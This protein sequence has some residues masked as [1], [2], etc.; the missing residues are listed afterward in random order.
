MTFHTRF[1]SLADFQ[2]GGVEVIDD[3]PKHYVFSN[4]FDVASRSK[5]WERV[6]VAKNFEYVIEAARATGESPYWSARHDEF[7]LCMDGEVEVELH[8]LDQPARGVEDRDGAHRLDALPAGKRMG[9]SVLRRG[10]MALLP[11]HSAY[12]LRAAAPSAVVFQTIEGPETIARWGE[13]CQTEG[14]TVGNRGGAAKPAAKSSGQ[15]PL[16]TRF[17]VGAPDGDT[18][19]RSF[20]AGGFEFRR[21]RYFAYISHGEIHHQIP[22]DAFLRALMRDVA[23]GFFYGTVN[24]D[25]VLGTTNF[26]GE[27]EMF[28]GAKN[29]AFTRAGRDVTER[30]ASADL[31]KSFKAILRDWTNEGFDPFAAPLET[32]AAFGAKHGSN[33]AAIERQRVSARRMV[34]LPG[35]T[36]L[37]TD[38]AGFPVNRMFA[39]VPQDQ[40]R[41]EVEAGFEN[42]V[43]A[44]NL[45]GYLSRS[46]VTWNPS[47][48]SVLRDSLFCPTSEEYILPIDHGNDRVEWFI[49]LSDEI[50]WDVKDGATGRPRARVTMRAGDVAAMPADIRHRGYSTKR[51]MLLVWENGSPSIPEMI[52]T[53]KAPVVPVAF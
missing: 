48:C 6:A 36:G 5:P 25:E 16:Q 9:R 1:G 3:N 27:V 12:R 31:M 53:G 11:K 49:Q 52:R 47:V 26:Y 38:D 21:D 41:V 23:W 19:Y 35:D 28:L 8:R 29:E 39:D 30:F 13:I 45:F 4:V 2:K 32:A 46:D 50:V 43:A 7:V 10:H 34:G 33:D 24:F 51:S 20:C 22:A 37:R 42:D 17:E 18:G 15:L 44:F 40:P 14:G